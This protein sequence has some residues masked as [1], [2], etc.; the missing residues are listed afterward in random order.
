[1]VGVGLGDAHAGRYFYHHVDGVGTAV[2]LGFGE[3]GLKLG[4]GDGGHWVTST[5]CCASPF[6]PLNS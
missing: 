4:R 6:G 1:M 2:V 5:R 3:D